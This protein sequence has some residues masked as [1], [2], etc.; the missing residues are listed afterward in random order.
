VLQ[1]HPNECK[2]KNTMDVD[3]F[4]PFGFM[5]F[6]YGVFVI[7]LWYFYGFY[8]FFGGLSLIL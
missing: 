8:G 6:L 5:W 3:T 4:Y 7:F 1:I 2:N